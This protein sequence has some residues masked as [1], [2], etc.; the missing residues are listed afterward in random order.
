M[1]VAK[2]KQIGRLFDEAAS[3]LEHRLS[4]DPTRNMIV[5]SCGRAADAIALLADGCHPK[6]NE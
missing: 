5:C 1:D 4:Y 2:I 6:G 3:P